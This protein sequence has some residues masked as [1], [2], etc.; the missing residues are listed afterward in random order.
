MG[1]RCHNT[2][3][4]VSALHIVDLVSIS[5]IPYS[6]LSIQSQ[7]KPLSTTKSG[8]KRQKRKKKCI[9]LWKIYII[10]W[11]KISKYQMHDIT[12]WYWYMHRK[13]VSKCQ[14]CHFYIN[15]IFAL[16]HKNKCSINTV[17]L[18]AYSNPQLFSD[19]L[20]TDSMNTG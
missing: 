15:S 1:G 6:S 7:E 18:W 16:F 5:G 3:G 19:G 11:T 13:M 10:W 2:A 9:N 8:P 20:S 17:S 12:N 4:T 14:R